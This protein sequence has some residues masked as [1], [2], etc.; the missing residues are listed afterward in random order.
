MPKKKSKPGAVKKP[1]NKAVCGLCGKKTNLTRTDCCGNWICDD[2]HKYVM[3]SYD[4]NSCH[5]NHDQYTLCAY[6]SHNEHTGDWKGCKECE[7]SLGTEMYV[8]HGT[9]EYNFDVLENP[10]AYEPT[11]CSKCGIVIKLTTDSYSMSGGDQ[12]WCEKCTGQKFN[13]C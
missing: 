13:K 10:P 5:R 9:N 4:K 12:Y 6:H 11:K 3:F 1:Q 8:W 2:E 7:E